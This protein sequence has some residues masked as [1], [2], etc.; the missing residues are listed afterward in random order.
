MNNN[1]LSM[2]KKNRNDKIEQ[3]SKF[4]SEFYIV[5]KNIISQ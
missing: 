2:K 4:L 5:I 1:D 3:K